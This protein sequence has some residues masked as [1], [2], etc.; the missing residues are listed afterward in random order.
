M[1]E[2]SK[3]LYVDYVNITLQNPWNILNLTNFKNWNYL[4]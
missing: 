4:E 1:K 3:K 2:I